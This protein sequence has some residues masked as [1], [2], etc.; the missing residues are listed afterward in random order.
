MWNGRAHCGHEAEGGYL[1]TYTLTESATGWT[2]C[3]RLLYRSRET[4][5]QAIQHAR[6]LFPFPIVE[7]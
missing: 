6:T 4:V 5:L 7:R 1:Y 2:E 3:L